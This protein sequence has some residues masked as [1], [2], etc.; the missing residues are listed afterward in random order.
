MAGVKMGVDAYRQEEVIFW[1]YQ[2]ESYT[3]KHPRPDR[4]SYW[5]SEPE[6]T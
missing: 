6:I 2:K 3:E 5:P 4:K 1:D